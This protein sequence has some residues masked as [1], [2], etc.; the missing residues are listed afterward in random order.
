MIV[1]DIGANRGLF[2]KG[3]L[4]LFDVKRCYMI[5]ASPEN[6]QELT[7]IHDISLFDVSDFQKLE[8]RH[9]A[10]G[11]K[12]GTVKLFTNEEGSP[13]ASLY[14]HVVCGG[15]SDKLFDLTQVVSVP[16]QTLDWLASAEL[17]HDI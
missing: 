13:R 1:I 4:K 9:F 17:K 6:F 16:M 3:M 15:P 10:M 12:P 8:A 14:P 7:D 11:S 5:D 2:S